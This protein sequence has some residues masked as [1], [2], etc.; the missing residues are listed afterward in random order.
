MLASIS[1]EFIVLKNVR[2]K[3]EKYGL[4]IW[5]KDYLKIRNSRIMRELEF[6]EDVLFKNFRFHSISK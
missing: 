2:K 3:R 4:S 6:N 5:A 1:A